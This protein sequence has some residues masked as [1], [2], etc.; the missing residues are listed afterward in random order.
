MGLDF[1]LGFRVLRFDVRA[2]DG[3]ADDFFIFDRFIYQL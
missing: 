3:I 1:G 2:D